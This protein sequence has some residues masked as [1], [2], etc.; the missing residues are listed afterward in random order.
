MRR[1]GGGGGG[2]GDG[3]V[4]AIFAVIYYLSHV[5]EGH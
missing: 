1:G 3:M 5:G 2:G 4:Y